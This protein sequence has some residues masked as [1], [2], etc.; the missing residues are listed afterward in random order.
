MTRRRRSLTGEDV[1][2]W[3][4]ATRDVKPLDKLP[5]IV[6]EADVLMTPKRAARQSGLPTLPQVL[7]AVHVRAAPPLVGAAPNRQ[8]ERSL[9]RGEMEI[10]A[11][12]DLHGQTELQAHSRLMRF[13]INAAA[14]D[15]RR[16]L[17][18]TGKG[19]EGQGLLKTRLP[20]WLTEGELR[21]LV[22]AVHP[23]HIKDG[24]D[25]AFYVILRRRRG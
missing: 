20:G 9:K 8:W 1:E 6:P 21:P 16:L 15:A 17:V 4:Y 18:I 25:G 14:M 10:D 23:A 11:R 13:V 22:M 12:L 19:R 3:R 2:L 5:N 7:A 24:G